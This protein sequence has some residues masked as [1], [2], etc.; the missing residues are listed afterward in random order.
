MAEWKNG[1]NLKIE[2]M[3]HTHGLKSGC[4][5]LM[6][7]KSSSYYNKCD[8]VISIVSIILVTL[9]AT[10]SVSTATMNDSMLYRILIGI[11]LYIIAFITAMKEF[12]N[13]TQLTEK[14][15]LY[16]MRFSALNN[17][18]QSQLALDQDDRQD[19][20]DYIGWIN[21]EMDN[22]LVSNP[23]IPSKIKRKAENKFRFLDDNKEVYKDSNTVSTEIVSCPIPSTV[24][25]IEPLNKKNKGQVRFL[26]E[27]NRL[28][29]H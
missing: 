23:T 2:K 7:E 11:I 27:L 22:L 25:D 3:I 14:H 9:T 13:L 28:S 19:G 16:S 29:D 21:T 10:G 20:R 24:I 15:R 26:Y 5:K 17:N 18:I 6:H 12:L 1:W 8:K 4:Y